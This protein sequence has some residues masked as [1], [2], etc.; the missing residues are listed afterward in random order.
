MQAGRG[1]K[2]AALAGGHWEHFHHVADIGV[3]GI[4]PSPDAAFVQAALAM[5]AVICEPARIRPLAR[6]EFS[7]QAPDLELLLVDWLNALIYE[8]SCRSM[9]FSRFLVHIEGG[10][11]HG[12]A[13]GERADPLRHSPAVEVKGATYTALEVR[14]KAAGLWLAQCVVDV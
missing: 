8:M 10:R 3:R 9:L 11:L 2:A 1:E 12:E 7:C 14:E 4:G 6:V 5:T 13:W